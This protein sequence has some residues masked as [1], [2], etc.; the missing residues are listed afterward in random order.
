MEF[1]GLNSLFTP[2]AAKRGQTCDDPPETLQI[3]I[4]LMNAATRRPRSYAS[5]TL[6]AGRARGAR[7]AVDA[8]V[9]TLS[10]SRRT[11]LD[12][13]LLLS[14]VSFPPFSAPHWRRSVRARVCA[15]TYA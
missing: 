12:Q 11:R 13:T 2:F 3:W 5:S 1:E 9:L 15:R 8:A 6:G 7:G 10:D 4:L 14:A